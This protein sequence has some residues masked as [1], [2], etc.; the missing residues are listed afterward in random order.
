VYRGDPAMPESAFVEIPPAEQAAMLTA[1][2]FVKLAGRQSLRDV[3]TIMAVPSAALALLGLTPPK[4]STLAEANERRSAT[5]YETPLATFY[6]RCRA[7]AAG[8]SFPFKSPLFS[9]NSTLLSHCLSL[10]PRARFRR[11][12][13]G[14][15]GPHASGSRGLHPGLCRAHRGQAE[16]YHGGP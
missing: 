7:F 5:L 2:V 12:K 9:L 3:V 1:L 10:F 14:V 15:K 11:A 16:R 6:A 13:G 4:R 8:H